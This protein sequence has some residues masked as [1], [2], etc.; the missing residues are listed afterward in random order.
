VVV[1]TAALVS[2]AGAHDRFWA[3]NVLGTR[4]ALALDA[5]LR[6]GARRFV[7]FSSVTVYGLDYPDGADERWPVRPTSSPYAQTKIAS[8][9]V[10]LSE[11]R[12]ETVVVR[13]GDVYGRGSRPW[14][15]VPAEALRSGRIALPRGGVVTPVYVDD[16]VEGVYAAATRGPA[17][18]VFNLVGPRV[19]ASEYFGLL[20]DGLGVPRPRELPRRVLE[21]AV[22]LIPG[23]ESNPE[24]IRYLARRNG[25]SWAKARAVLGWEPR[26]PLREGLQKALGGQP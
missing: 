22:R 4:H 12:L 8:E 9:Q 23:P 18:E 24:S 7:H 5:A 20:A 13:P 14:I 21:Q 16:L 1:H 2:L 17:G 10:V 26:T 3:V 19:A 25:Y 11:R 15:D 6:G